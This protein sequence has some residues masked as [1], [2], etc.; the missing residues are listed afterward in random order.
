M[1]LYDRRIKLKVVAAAVGIYMECVYG[2][3]HE[4]LTIKNLIAR[5]VPRMLILN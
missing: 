2:I 1:V 4:E 5:W 3:L